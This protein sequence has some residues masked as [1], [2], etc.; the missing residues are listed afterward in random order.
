MASGKTTVAALLAKASGIG[1][2][3]LDEIIEKEQGKTI[4]ELFKQGGELMFRKIEHNV[5]KNIME[6]DNE[7]IV[8]LGGGTPCYAGNHEFLQRDD[9]IS[10]YLKA[11]IGELAKRIRKQQKSRPVLDGL[12][13]N[14]LEDFIAK[15][16]F[17]RS[18]FYYKAGHVINVDGKTAEM[19]ANE[20][21][22]LF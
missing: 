19:V 17:D 11:E 7:V 5:L 13:D 1:Y 9:V 15:H 21:M 2:I 6:Q 3:D 20:I 4:D 22:S 14:E 18:Y 10:V 8:S 12:N 16:L